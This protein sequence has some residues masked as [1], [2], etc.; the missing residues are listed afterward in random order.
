[1]AG[2]SKGS[3][4]S[5][6]LVGTVRKRAVA[7]GERKVGPR[8]R[9]LPLLLADVFWSGDPQTLNSVWGERR[10]D[11]PAVLDAKF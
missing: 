11:R 4:G 8:R 7:A 10:E 6:D 9:L 1:L 2:R 5:G 3:T